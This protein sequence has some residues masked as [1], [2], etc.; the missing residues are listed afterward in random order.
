MNDRKHPIAKALGR[1][2]G[3]LIRLSIFSIV[4]WLAYRV[5]LE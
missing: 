3:K 5:V 4:F 2:T 1:L